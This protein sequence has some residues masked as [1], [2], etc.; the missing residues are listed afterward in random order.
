MA[1]AGFYFTGNDKERDSVA[2][3][4]CEK[5]L[6]GWEATDD[7][8]T[9]HVRHSPDCEFAKLMLAEEALSYY[10]FFDIK[11]DLMKR[12]F[13]KNSAAAQQDLDNKYEEMKRYVMLKFK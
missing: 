2:C 5:A 3:F 11:G 1:E 7:P 13:A 9:E 12:L 4:L 6:D 8:W 10:Q